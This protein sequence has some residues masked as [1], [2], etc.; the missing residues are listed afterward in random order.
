MSFYGF[1]AELR[2]LHPF[3]AEVGFEANPFAMSAFGRLGASFFLSR[4]RSLRTG[5]GQ[6]ITVSAYGGYRFMRLDGIGTDT[7]HGAS[8][9]VGGDYY[10]WLSHHF[11]FN[12]H[13]GGGGG[14]WLASSNPNSP[15]FFPEVRVALGLAF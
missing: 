2:F 7:Y 5:A 13:I 8:L 3:V 14:M 10:I 15:I 12:F 9:Y 4:I 6:E 1:S 11:G